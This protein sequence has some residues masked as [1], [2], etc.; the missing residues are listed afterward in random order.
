[1]VTWLQSRF[2]IFLSSEVWTLSIVLVIFLIVSFRLGGGKGGAKICPHCPFTQPTKFFKAS[3]QACQ[4][5]TWGALATVAPP[6]R[7]YAKKWMHRSENDVCFH[8]KFSLSFTHMYFI[9]KS[10]VHHGMKNQQEPNK[11]QWSVLF[12]LLF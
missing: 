5:P 1:M 7:N 10:F 12:N 2:S 6:P 8:S 9:M 11:T 3:Q 4:Y